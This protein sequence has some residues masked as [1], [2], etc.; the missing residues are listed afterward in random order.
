MK[1]NR[2]GNWSWLEDLHE[3]LTPAAFIVAA[4]LVAS[5]FG[6]SNAVP[7]RKSSTTKQ[8]SELNSQSH[9]RRQP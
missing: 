1:M 3:F 6:G 7:S 5:I 4:L 9:E 8:S 2:D